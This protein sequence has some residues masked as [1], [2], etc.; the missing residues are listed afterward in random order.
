[1]SVTLHTDVGDMK[2]ELQCEKCPKTCENFLALCA[3]DYYIGSTFHRNI[4]GFI[5]QTG[6][7]ENTGKGGQSIWGR[8]FEDEFSDDLKHDARGTVSM[9]NSGPDTNASQFFIAYAPHQSLDLKYTIFG[10]VIDGLEALDELEKMAVNPKTYRPL[11]DTRVN[12][13]TIHANPLAG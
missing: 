3:S 7:P 9:A 10:K 1:M 11:T 12:K 8:K 6:D 13:I 2:I 5:V 4:K